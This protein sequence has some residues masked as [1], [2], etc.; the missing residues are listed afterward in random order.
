MS[1]APFL[2]CMQLSMRPVAG[3]R[4]AYMRTGRVSRLRFSVL[5]FA[6]LVGAAQAESGLRYLV[7]VE[8][9][10]FMPYSLAPNSNY[11][12][13]HRDLLD[14]FA[15]TQG[16]EFDY[17]PLPYIRNAHLFLA[18]QLDFQFPDDPNWIPELKY[19]ETIHYSQ[20]AVDYTDA[21]L[22]MADDHGKGVEQLKR[23]GILSGWTP[24]A[25]YQRQ[26]KGDLEFV[27]R[28]SL[29][30][31]V[32][33]LLQGDIDGIYA[34]QRVMERYLGKRNLQ[35]V[36]RVDKGLPYR[37]S[38]FCLASMRHPQL[39]EAF[40]RFLLEHAQEVELLKVRHQLR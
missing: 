3:A 7:G 35:S 9:Q 14:L 23:L 26:Q 20:P 24:S 13:F 22:R 19:K 15:R 33:D 29:S 10:E 5:L 30:A 38:G 40:N 11:Q 2:R 28:A 18:G 8:G 34:N 27:E 16:I 17:V 37:K 25:Y 39:I 21:V 32:H 12:G 36:I 4:N 31:L 1:L 6:L